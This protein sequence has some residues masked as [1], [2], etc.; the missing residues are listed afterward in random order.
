MKKIL[1]MCLVLFLFLV[2]TSCKEEATLKIKNN[3]SAQIWFTID[4]GDVTGLTANST[5]SKTYSSDRYVIVDYTGEHVFSDS[6][7]LDIELGKTTS[8]NVYADG[9]AIKINNN[10]SVTIYSVY[11]SPSTSS[12]WGVDQLGSELLYS[13]NYKLWTVSQNTWDI[14]LVD[15][16]G[17]SYYAYDKYVPMDETYTINFV[18]SYKG[19]H[20]GKKKDGADPEFNVSYK[21]EKR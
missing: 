11:L 7:T 15:I 6:E 8:L 19:E 4:N 12:S 2:L 3:S 10:S 16:A 20:A 9:G 21:V 14:K 18:D 17:N 5:W 1:V 13:G